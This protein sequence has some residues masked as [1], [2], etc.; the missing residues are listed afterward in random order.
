MPKCHICGK[1]FKR[2]TGS[3]LKK[4]GISIEE[5]QRKHEPQKAKIKHAVTFLN[6][7]YVTLRYKFLEYSNGKPYTVYERNRGWK[8]C[9]KDLI[10]HLKGKKTIG[11]YFLNDSS[12][13]IGLDLDSAD[14]EILQ[15]VY[16]TLI[17]F[18][19]GHKN[20]LCSFSGKKG[21]HVDIFLSEPLEKAIINKF[22]ETILYE[23]NATKKEIELRGGGNQAYKL[24]LGYHHKT[25]AYCFICDENGAELDIEHLNTIEKLNIQTIC[26]IVEINY[27]QND[28]AAMM[29]EH[30]ELCG[31][32]SLLPSYD[33][34]NE[35]QIKRIEGILKRGV[36]EKGKRHN[37]ILEV[38]AFYKDILGYCLSDTIAL[39]KNWIKEKWNTSI[40]DR[41]LFTDVENTCK[42]VYSSGFK[43]NVRA[44]R[45]SISLPEI[46]EVFTIKTGNKLQTEALRRLYYIFLLHSKAYGDSEGIFFMTYNQIATMGGNANTSILAKQINKLAEIG[47]LLIVERNVNAGKTGNSF[48]RPN[49]YKLPCF[50]QIDAKAH[51]FQICQKSEKCKECYLIAYCHLA[52]AKERRLEIKGKAFKSLPDCEVNQLQR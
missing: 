3:H 9:D 26:D 4:H 37:T 33:N 15:K 18:G 20:I 2:L 29:L 47:K 17:S 31:N 51:D 38:A 21:Y 6:E 49:K 39:L 52:D 12:K 14:I 11:V 5:Y 24:P 34:T 46:R 48:K 32:I 23:L 36:H 50:V 35:S 41:E 28:N 45:I 43:F 25:G 22:Y 44:N 8:L 10:S 30:A 19:I 7:H 42:S 16:A 40:I 13:F 1:E 27:T